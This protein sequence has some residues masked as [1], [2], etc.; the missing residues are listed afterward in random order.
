MQPMIEA[1]FTSEEKIPPQSLSELPFL[2]A[3]LAET[4]GIYPAGLSR[5]PLVAA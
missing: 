2:R 5:Q 3:R 4:N 1:A